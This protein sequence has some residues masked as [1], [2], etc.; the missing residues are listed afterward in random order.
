[1]ISAQVAQKER[2]S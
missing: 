2:V 1:V